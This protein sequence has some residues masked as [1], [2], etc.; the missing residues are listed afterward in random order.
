MPRIIKNLQYDLN[1]EFDVTEAGSGTQY[2]YASQDSLE[3]WWRL[4]EDVSI[5]GDALDSSPHFRDGTFNSAQERPSFEAATAIP[6]GPKGQTIQTGVCKF[7]DEAVGSGDDVDIGGDWESRIGLTGTSQVTMAAWVKMDVA[8]SNIGR[9]FS[10]GSPGLLGGFR[11]IIRT[12]GDVYFTANWT[13]STSSRALWETTTQPLPIDEWAHIAITYNPGAGVSADP[14]LYI[15]GE[16]LGAFPSSTAASGTWKGIYNNDAYIGAGDGTAAAGVSGIIADVAIWSNILSENEIKALYTLSQQ[17]ISDDIRS[18][19]LDNPYRVI[20]NERDNATGSYPTILRTTGRTVTLG[21]SPISPYDSTREIIFGPADDVHYADVLQRVDHDKYLDNWIASP[22]QDDVLGQSH[23][24]PNSKYEMFAPGVVSPFVSTQGMKISIDQRG[25]GSPRHDFEPF[26]E[27]RVYLGD[28]HFYHAGTPNSVYPG[29]SSPLDDKIQIVIPIDSSEERTISRFNSWQMHGDY[30]SDRYPGG[31]F[32]VCVSAWPSPPVF[33][34]D[35]PGKHLHYWNKFGTE[36]SGSYHTGFKYYNPVLRVWEDQGFQTS[37]GIIGPQG[38]D[39][40]TATDDSI[41]DPPWHGGSGGTNR[42]GWGTFYTM[43]YHGKPVNLSYYS[44]PP[45]FIAGTNQGWGPWGDI[46]TWELDLGKDLTSPSDPVNWPMSTEFKQYQFTM[47]HHMGFLAGTYEDLLEMGYDKIGAPTMT[48]MGPNNATFHATASNVFKMSNYIAHPF[49]LEKAVIEIPIRVRRKNGNIYAN[50]PK[51]GKGNRGDSWSTEDAFVNWDVKFP[52]GVSVDSSIRDIDNYVFFLYRQARDPGSAQDSVE[53]FKSS[54]RFLIASGSVACWSPG[55]FNT[56]IQ[57]EIDKR[58]LPHN[59]AV[60]IKLLQTHDSAGSLLPAPKILDISG[61]DAAGMEASFTGSIR[62]EMTPAVASGQFLGGTRLAHRNFA[63]D[64]GYA[65]PHVA[66]IP[67]AREINTCGVFVPSQVGSIVVQDFWPGGTTSPR[68]VSGAFG[69]TPTSKTAGGNHDTSLPQIRGVVFSLQS[70]CHFNGIFQGEKATSEAFSF[71]LTFNGAL[72]QGV[73]DS[74]F[75]SEGPGF[76]YIQ[77]FGRDAVPMWGSRPLSVGPGLPLAYTLGYP[78]RG[79]FHNSNPEWTYR[80]AHMD[81]HGPIAKS[82]LTEDSRPFRLMSGLRTQ[83]EK[84]TKDSKWLTRVDTN[85]VQAAAGIGYDITHP[86]DY[87]W[88]CSSDQFATVLAPDNSGTTTLP[89]VFGDLPVST[90]SPYVLLP[91][92]ELILGCDAGISSVPCSGTSPLAY[93]AGVPGDHC[94][95]NVVDGWGFP[96]THLLNLPAGLPTSGSL[97]EISGSFMVFEKGPAKLT[98]FGSMIR[99]DKEKLFELN[100][101]LSSDSIHEALH[102]DNPVVDQFDIENRKELSD[103]YTSDYVLGGMYGT[104]LFDDFHKNYTLLN[105]TYYR[106]SDC[107]GGIYPYGDGPFANQI[108]R[109]RA[110]DFAKGSHSIYNIIQTRPANKTGIYIIPIFIG[111]QFY[112]INACQKLWSFPLDGSKI[113]GGAIPGK[114]EAT[115]VIG[116]ATIPAG[117]VSPSG[118][119]HIGG[120]PLDRHGVKSWN[121]EMLNSSKTS[122]MLRA[123]VATDFNERYFDTIMPQ[124]QDWASRSGFIVT[125]DIKN[126]QLEIKD[127]INKEKG[128]RLNES[129]SAQ[130][131]QAGQHTM[132]DSYKKALPYHL[133]NSERQTEQSFQIT[134]KSFPKN[135]GWT[136]MDDESRLDITD[137]LQNCSDEFGPG[138]SRVT[139][140]NWV[141]CHSNLGYPGNVAM[142]YWSAFR[143]ILDVST[144]QKACYDVLFRKGYDMSFRRSDPSPTQLDNFPLLPA[145]K[146][147]SYYNSGVS[148][149]PPDPANTDIYVYTQDV[150]RLFHNMGPGAAH[151][152]AY[153]IMDTSPKFTTAVYRPGRYGQNRDMLEQRKFSK[154]YITPTTTRTINSLIPTLQAVIGSGEQDAPI[155]C[156]FVDSADG[157]SIVDPYTTDCSN[158]DLE[159]SSSC[160]FTDGHICNRYEPKPVFIFNARISCV[161]KGT[162]I[163]TDSGE[164]SVEDVTTDTRVL[165]HDFRTSEMG[166][167]EVLD[168][169]SNT[170]S[171]WC[172]IRTESGFELSCSLDHPIMSK[173]EEDLWEL[174]AADASPGDHTWVLIDGELRDD[175]IKSVEIFEESVEVYNMTVKDVHT[176][177]SNGILSHNAN[178]QLNT[179]TAAAAARDSINTKGGGKQS[180]RIPMPPSWGM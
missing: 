43:F 60:S 73:N 131:G 4:N 23:D 115:S 129:A 46:P 6:T 111:G 42:G 133:M 100:Q 80:I 143:K 24:D 28:T 160:P 169:F 76:P 88:F 35:D 176:Y 145:G 137:G 144:E 142:S 44:S 130:P 147:V 151:G 15:N 95:V 68:H 112:L 31:S 38:A 55:A 136:S 63:P 48:G 135:V 17:N 167:F 106:E 101:N 79:K 71:G 56:D 117:L 96:N 159:A 125:T 54:Q 165:S 20:L 103:G 150:I 41:F 50:R 10:F 153:G 72:V 21:N 97:S 127:F 118:P 3:G 110:I 40:V 57:A 18:G 102:F 156:Y 45:G 81:D 19:Y 11:I 53:D 61:S 180:P 164:I 141:G 64:T 177:F 116:P 93:P 104:F 16:S 121:S 126:R 128:C 89:I 92:D 7:E 82:R 148:P 33:Y 94:T 140:N 166:Y 173:S 158:M 91:G 175:V 154:F 26:D 107:Y 99:D 30:G 27:S 58:G 123:V 124:V 157:V 105:G 139:W 62:I 86:F 172:K 22:N 36:F 134:V 70:G 59:P 78:L 77:Y 8:T 120:L 75:T 66:V 2:K 108:E 84:M 179:Q 32:P 155:T 138:W 5:S 47:S 85:L 49:A 178:L 152:Y 163:Q 146:M 83:N 14:Q 113:I 29:F 171:G 122:T 109:V 1:K 98:L 74:Y 13:G 39:W 168:T 174:K 34:P 52:N 87:S 51:D 12:D 9:L 25:V 170:V 114:I 119:E 90:P 132:K 149:L 162:Q 67:T 161:I 65:D 69:I 37:A